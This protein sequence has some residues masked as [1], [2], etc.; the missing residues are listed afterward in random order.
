MAKTFW[1]KVKEVLIAKGS[2]RGIKVLIR[3]EEICPACGYDGGRDLEAAEIIL[4]KAHTKKIS[5]KGI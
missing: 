4:K 2:K 1:D 3:S 5:M